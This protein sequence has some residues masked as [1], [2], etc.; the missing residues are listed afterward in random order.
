[1]KWSAC[2]LGPVAPVRSIDN[3]ELSAAPPWAARRSMNRGYDNGGDSGCVTHPS[4]RRRGWKTS[5]YRLVNGSRAISRAF[6]TATAT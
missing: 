5:R 3:Q 1:M 2:E 4:P 6:F